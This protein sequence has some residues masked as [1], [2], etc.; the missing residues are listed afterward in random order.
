MAIS[1][2]FDQPLFLV[3]C[4]RAHLD[5]NT[6]DWSAVFLNIFGSDVVNATF[7]KK[8]KISPYLHLL[9]SF[10]AIKQTKIKLEIDKTA[11]DLSVEI[12]FIARA[13]GPLCKE[14]PAIKNVPKKVC[15]YALTKHSKISLFGDSKAHRIL[16]LGG[17]KN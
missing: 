10:L 7:E 13:G 14:A 16:L 5:S 12:V 11:Y 8:Q 9:L 1:K 4:Y 6:T 15:L 2:G 3:Y 17:H